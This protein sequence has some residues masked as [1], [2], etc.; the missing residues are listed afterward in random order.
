MLVRGHRVPVL[1]TSLESTT[2]DLTEV[3]T[4]GLG[5]RVL[6]LGEDGSERITLGD[7]ASWQGTRELQVLMEFTGRMPVTYIGARSESSAGA[8]G[9]GNNGRSLGIPS[10][11]VDAA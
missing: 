11:G 1:S 7:M 4:A 6:A 3:P 5:D 9:I 2:L 8:D 10:T